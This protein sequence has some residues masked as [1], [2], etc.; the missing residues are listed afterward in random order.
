MNKLVLITGILGFVL[1]SC[2]HHTLK[3]DASGTFEATEVIVS[4]EV[5]GKLESFE[6]EEGENLKKDQ[7]VGYVD[8][9]QL[10][11]QK[12]QAETSG[13]GA[14]VRRP[15]ISVQVSSTREQLAKAEFERNRIIR[16]LNDNATTQKQLDDVNSQIQVLKKTLDAQVNQLSTSVNALNEENNVYQI[17]FAQIEDLLKKCKIKNP[18]AGTI[19]NKYVEEKELVTQG[20]PLYKIADTKKMILRAYLVAPQIEKIKVG[21]VVTVFINTENGNQKSYKGKISWI[22]DKAEFTPKTIQTQDERQNLVY[23]VKIDVPNTDGKIKI[24]MYGDV[25]FRD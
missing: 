1:F 20:R 11:L 16:L 24:G 19:L 4:S 10:Y 23:A 12:L 8:S 6:L 22:S 3:H 2:N 9:T 21:Q 17:K 18:V 15:D 7:Y 25:D 13:K 5:D 14:R